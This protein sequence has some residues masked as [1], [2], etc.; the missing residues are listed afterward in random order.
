[1]PE[2]SKS[3]E[4][5]G[6]IY[7]M[8]YLSEDFADISE[9]FKDKLRF[10]PWLANG[11]DVVPIGVSKAIGLTKTLEILGDTLP[12]KII[13]FGD[14]SNDIELIEMAD[15]GVAMGNAVE[16]LK[17]I[18]DFVTKNIE[19]DGIYYACEQLGLFATASDHD[20]DDGDDVNTMIAQLKEAIAAEPNKLDHYWK[21]KSLYSSYTRQS[22]KAVKVLEDAL[23]YFPDDVKLLAELAAVYE[24][25]IE[26]YAKAKIYYEQVLLL[27]PEHELA[28]NALD[29][30]NDKSIHPNL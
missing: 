11:A 27:D 21:L 14:G 25:E 18:A 1:L 12:K 10:L 28:L 20:H 3:I 6:A 23:V 17:T 7:Q 8:W 2:I 29:V 24:F 26:D 9:K 5:H 15:I 22:K 16:S 13:F 19:D 4:R 30:L